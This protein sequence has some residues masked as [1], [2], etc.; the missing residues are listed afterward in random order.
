MD[1]NP[2]D[3][4]AKHSENSDVEVETKLRTIYPLVICYIAIEHGPFVDHLW[5]FPI[6]MV[7]FHSFHHCRP[8]A[9]AMA[10][11]LR[12]CEGKQSQ[13]LR[14]LQMLEDEAQP[15]PGGGKTKWPMGF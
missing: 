8:D 12:S 4:L 3:F 2:P 15:A 14:L 7:I 11:V 5:I 1:D 10:S 13:Q 6:N 9:V